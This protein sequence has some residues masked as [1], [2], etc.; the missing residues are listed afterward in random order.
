MPLTNTKN[1][2]KQ[3]AEEGQAQFTAHN[4]QN[5]CNYY[6]MC[7]EEILGGDFIAPTI[8]LLIVCNATLAG[9]L[10]V[11]PCILGISGGGGEV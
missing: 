6:H 1:H 8:G 9:M 4:L 7:T 10:V 2:K 11:A 3:V 5:S